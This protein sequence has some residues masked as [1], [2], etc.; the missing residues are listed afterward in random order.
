MACRQHHELAGTIEKHGIPRDQERIGALLGEPRKSCIDIANGAGIED[1]DLLSDAA[2]GGLNVIHL[3][4]GIERTCVHE[5]SDRR[6]VGPQ[7]TQQPQPLRLEVE[8]K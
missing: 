6:G 7:L 3:Y 8:N 5:N 2:G 4:F 1:I